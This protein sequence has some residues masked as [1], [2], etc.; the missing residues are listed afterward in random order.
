MHF[1]FDPWELYAPVLNF[2][3]LINIDYFYGVWWFYIAIAMIALGAGV[4]QNEQ[5][6][7]GLQRM[8]FAI[9][10]VLG[11]LIA[12]ISMSAGPVF[13]DQVFAGGNRFAEWLSYAQAHGFY[14][15]R[16]FRTS[17]YLWTIYG[18]TTGKL[19]GGISAFPS[20]HVA[21]A[22]LTMLYAFT[23]NRVAGVIGIMWLALIQVGS[24]LLG[25]HYAVD[26]YFS[27]AAV[28][29]LWRI[30]IPKEVRG[31]RFPLIR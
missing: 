5:I 28:I 9:W 25:W 16:A 15:T 6:R 2:I 3:P 12:S 24:V 31:G 8:Y 21:I 13:Y 19:G 18:D 26:G 27:I 4:E 22:S 29:I 1:G 30:F 11:L 7:L 14:D 23:F 17:E 20:I 10:G